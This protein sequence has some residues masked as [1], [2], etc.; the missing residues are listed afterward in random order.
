MR[1]G[2]RKSEFAAKALWY[3]IFEYICIQ[4]LVFQLVVRFISIYRPPWCYGNSSIK[5]GL[6]TE[7]D[8]G[9]ILKLKNSLKPLKLMKNCKTRLK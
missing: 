7:I 1:R 9:D 3:G 4:S 6:K 5:K 8:Q 2:N